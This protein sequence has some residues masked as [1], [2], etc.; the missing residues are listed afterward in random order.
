MKRDRAWNEDAARKQI[1]QLFEAWGP[2]DPLTL[3]GR[4]K[5]SAIMF[6]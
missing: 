4:R 5:L 1:V 6:A 3:S 2:T